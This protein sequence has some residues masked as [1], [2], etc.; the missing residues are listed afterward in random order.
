MALLMTKLE[1]HDPLGVSGIDD[2]SDALRRIYNGNND[3]GIGLFYY[4]PGGCRIF[5]ATER[6]LDLPVHP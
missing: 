2:L 5:F 6:T 1:P 4:R 3:D